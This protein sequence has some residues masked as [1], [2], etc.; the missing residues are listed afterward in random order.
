MPLRDVNKY[1]NCI[2]GGVRYCD[3]T[4]LLNPS[5]FLPSGP[6]IPFVAVYKTQRDLES[7]TQDRESEC[8]NPLTHSFAFHKTPG[9]VKSIT[10]DAVFISATATLKT[11]LSSRDGSGHLCAESPFVYK[12][13]PA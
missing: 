2:S 11:T 7:E 5:D 6:D 10:G 9:Y 8:F 1:E 4:P 13:S 3:P 12:P